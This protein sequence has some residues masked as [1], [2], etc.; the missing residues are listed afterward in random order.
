M[1]F[2]ITSYNVCY[3]K[4]LR[5][6]KEESTDYCALPG[7]KGGK[8]KWPTLSEMHQRL[9]DCAF[10]EAHNAAADVAATAR[11]FLELARLGVIEPVKYG[12][13]SHFTENFRAANPH[14]IPE[15]KV[16]IASNFNH[17]PTEPSREIPLTGDTPVKKTADTSIPFTHL[18]V[19][20]QYSILD[21]AAEISG[22]IDKAKADGMVALA[23]TDHGN[24]FGLKEFHNKATKAGIK[25][26]LG[27]E[28]YVSY[29]FV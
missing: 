21:G 29:N 15:P 11:C 13:A 7:G 24:M 20:T 1:E 23:I 9:F 12:L 10:E 2:R 28:A 6:T 22:L 18:H 16:E 5:D 8:Y 3:T 26:I 19:H 17:Q 25:P 27:C 4:L 14:I